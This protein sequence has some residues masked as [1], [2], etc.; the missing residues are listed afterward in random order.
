MTRRGILLAYKILGPF[1]LVWAFIGLLDSI[2]LISLS[3]RSLP[4][5]LFGLMA[6][7]MY[8]IGFGLIPLAILCPIIAIRYRRDLPV[9]L[10]SLLL[11]LA[12]CALFGPLLAGVEDDEAFAIPGAALALAAVAAATWAGWFAEAPASD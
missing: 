1:G 7:V 4:E 3:E 9:M 5:P 6:A 11:F 2:G 12:I 10:P 8:L